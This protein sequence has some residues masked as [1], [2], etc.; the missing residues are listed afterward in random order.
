MSAMIFLSPAGDSCPHDRLSQVFGLLQG[1]GPV[2][3]CARFLQTTGPN[4][5]IFLEI[6]PLHKHLITRENIFK[7][8]LFRHPLGENENTLFAGRE[9][10][11]EVG[12]QDRRRSGQRRFSTA[13]KNRRN[14]PARRSLM[15]AYRMAS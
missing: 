15:F 3:D 11:T 13:R 9:A 2:F 14:R 1:L 4:E 7:L 6:K 8:L 5:V 12:V 10:T